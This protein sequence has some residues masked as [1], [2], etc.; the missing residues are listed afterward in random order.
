MHDGGLYEQYLPFGGETGEEEADPR[1]IFFLNS[2]ASGML[3][4]NFQGQIRAKDKYPCAFLM[5]NGTSRVCYP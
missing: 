3:P 1:L 4:K 2:E 5:S